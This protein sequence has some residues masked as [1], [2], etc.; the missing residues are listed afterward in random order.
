MISKR[1]GLKSQASFL[2][3]LDNTKAC[4]LASI[5]LNS[6]VKIGIVPTSWGLDEDSV[7]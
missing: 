4:H 1:A 6:Q 5:F 7:K 2:L 3:S